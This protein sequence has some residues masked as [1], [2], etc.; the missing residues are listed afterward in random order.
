MG[1]LAIQGEDD[2]YGTMRQIEEIAPTRGPLQ[3]EKLAACGHSPHRDQ[4]ER[5]TRLVQ[6]FLAQ[7]GR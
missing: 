1:V 3:L 6:A 4:T 2:A 5:V 7:P